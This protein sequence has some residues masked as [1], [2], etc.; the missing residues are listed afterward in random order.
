MRCASLADYLELENAVD[1]LEASA[2]FTTVLWLAVPIV[3]YQGYENKNVHFV[4]IM[5]AVYFLVAFCTDSGLC[6]L[7]CMLYDIIFTFM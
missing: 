5:I 3:D 4:T 7:V 6:W 2:V 1:Y